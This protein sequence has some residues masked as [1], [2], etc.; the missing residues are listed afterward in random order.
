MKEKDLLQG[1]RGQV[2]ILSGA[3]DAV[4]RMNRDVVIYSRAMG[5]FAEVFSCALFHCAE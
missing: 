3:G 2:F 4:E 5:G 1:L